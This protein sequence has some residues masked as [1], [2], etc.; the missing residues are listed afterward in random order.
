MNSE[1][2]I[3]NSC[4]LINGFTGRQSIRGK[5][6][7]G[8]CARICLG[9]AKAMGSGFSARWSFQ[10]VAFASP[11]YIVYSGLDSSLFCFFE[12][13]TVLELFR[14]HPPIPLFVQPITLWRKNKSWV[15]GLGITLLV[16]IVI[17]HLGTVLSFALAVK[18]TWANFGQSLLW[19]QFRIYSPIW[20][21][22]GT[23][24]TETNIK[25]A[26]DAIQLA[27]HWN[28]SKMVT[29]LPIAGFDILKWSN[30]TAAYITSSLHPELPNE[31]T[32]SST[33]IP[34]DKGSKQGIY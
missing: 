10:T 9:A 19:I 11:T 18:V 6:V 5:F 33:V 24:A 28:L 31:P 21:D 8:G 4:A 25:D 34:M 15:L 30:I 14:T 16:S 3:A 20:I 26:N 7:G 27:N 12:R 32:Q 23:S 17:K 29:G 22:S 13:E 2:L 1:K